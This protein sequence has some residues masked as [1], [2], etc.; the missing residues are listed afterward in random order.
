MSER[1][2]QRKFDV[3]FYMMADG[4]CP[5]MTFLDQIDKKLRTK[6]VKMIELLEDYGNDLRMPYSRHLEDGIFELRIAQ[7]SNIVRII[8]FF[9]FER[10]IIL[11]NGYIKKTQK[12]PSEE[13]LLAKKFKKDYCQRKENSCE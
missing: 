7:G 9:W 4:K 1:E 12:A 8:Y 5:I 6:A 10:K 13:I 3:Q 11:T 2:N